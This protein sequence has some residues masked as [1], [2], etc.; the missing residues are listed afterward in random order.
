MLVRDAIL[1]RVFAFRR[2]RSLAQLSVDD[3][4]KHARP[5]C[6]IVHDTVSRLSRT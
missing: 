1:T 6:A 3:L 2:G 4:L 5:W